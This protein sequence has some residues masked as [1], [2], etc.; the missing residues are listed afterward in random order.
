LVSFA[1]GAEAITITYVNPDPLNSRVFVGFANDASGNMTSDLVADPAAASRNDTVYGPLPPVGQLPS[2]DA[3]AYGG[4]EL[5]TN[6]NAPLGAGVRSVFAP[7]NPTFFRAHGETLAGTGFYS[8]NAFAHSGEAPSTTPTR[9]IVHVDPSGAEVAGTP[10]DVTV[11]GSIA[12]YVSV[13]AASVAD[14]AWNVEVLSVGTVMSGTA[15]QVVPGSTNFNDAGSITF[16][17]PLG[18]TFELLVDYDLSTSGSGAG[19]NSTSEITASLVEISAEIAPPPMFSAVSGQKLL[20]LDKY[21]ATSKAKTVLVLKDT[22]PGG[23]H[24][25]PSADPP[26]LSGTVVLFQQADPSNR[27]V[28][29][30]DASGWLFNKD[31]VAKF[32]NPLAAPGGAGARSAIVRPDKLVKLVA[33]NLGDGDS[34]SGDQSTHDID[35]SVLTSADVIVAVVTIYNAADGSTN[36]MCTQ[37]ESPLLKTVGGTGTRYLSKTSTLPATCP[38]CGNGIAEPGEECVT[39]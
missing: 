1:V 37:F 4:A 8:S 18:G 24:K 7:F 14:A 26:G 9:W 11:E 5:G 23:I 30:L 27:A 15:S 20:L 3:M 25:G 21:T 39:P 13:A 6:L 29:A 33:R 34:A 12:G 2:F 35:L 22:T 17:V 19:A 28:Y 31:K 38:V 10:A 16:S 32:V 36:T